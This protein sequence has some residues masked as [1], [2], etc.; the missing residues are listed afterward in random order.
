MSKLI[1]DSAKF[2]LDN[3]EPQDV[4]DVVKNMYDTVE[5]MRLLTALTENDI[6]THPVFVLYAKQI[7]KFA[8][9]STSGLKYYEALNAVEKLA[10]QSFPDLISSLGYNTMDGPNNSL[11]V[12]LSVNSANFN[13]NYMKLSD[14]YFE[15]FGVDA[16]PFSTSRTKSDW[17]VTFSDVSFY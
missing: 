14:L 5:K 12:M 16:K 2:I 1:K 17:V 11:V 3:L 7:A 15:Y 10:K 6:R 9:S 13:N 4:L 8:H